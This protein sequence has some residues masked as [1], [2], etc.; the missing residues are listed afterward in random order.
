MAV[1]SIVAGYAESCLLR[2]KYDESDQYRADQLIP[3]VA[4]LGYKDKTPKAYV[5]TLTASAVAEAVTISLQAAAGESL[6]IARDQTLYFPDDDVVATVLNSVTV[7]SAATTVDCRPLEGALTSGET[8]LSY[9]I[10]PILSIASGGFVPQRSA[11]IGDSRNK[12]QDFY[13]T[14][15]LIDR[16]ASS[17]GEGTAIRNDL[18]RAILE[19]AVAG[20]GRVYIETRRAIFDNYGVGANAWKYVGIVESDSPA[21]DA[22]GPFETVS[23][24]VNISGSPIRY[25]PLGMTFDEAKA[26]CPEDIYLQRLTNYIC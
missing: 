3:W 4:A 20:N 17:S 12:G 16:D 9:P 8:T 19:N 10:Y 2:A 11:S 13:K 24:N 22:S 6:L 14:K 21:S 5:L 15:A 18:G 7:T 23:F 26:K 25:T 1:S